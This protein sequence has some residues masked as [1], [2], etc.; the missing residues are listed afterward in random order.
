[1][2]HFLKGKI[3]VQVSLGKSTQLA[4]QA[5]C[6]RSI[7]KF[8]NL[9]SMQAFS[10]ELFCFGISS[11]FLFKSCA[12]CG[13]YLFLQL[14]AFCFVVFQGLYFIWYSI[15]HG[16]FF[17]EW[18]LSCSSSSAVASMSI[19][20]KTFCLFTKYSVK[21]ITVPCRDFYGIHTSYPEISV[22]LCNSNLHDQKQQNCLPLYVISESALF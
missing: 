20:K 18:T 12:Q 7:C 10:Y 16:L 4:F 8:Y 1:M 17:L 14:F 5:D 21:V 3:F 9:L 6:R 13:F 15:L 11:V 22:F 19:Y 2:L